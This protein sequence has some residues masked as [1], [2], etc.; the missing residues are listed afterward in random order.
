MLIVEQWDEECGLWRLVKAFI[1]KDG[2]DEVAHDYSVEVRTHAKWTATRA[3]DMATQVRIREE[4]LKGRY[5][6][7]TSRIIW[8]RGTWTDT[9]RD[10]WIEHRA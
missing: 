5:P 2:Q 7:C 1:P 9:G 8:V 10:G 6:L 4:R 3:A